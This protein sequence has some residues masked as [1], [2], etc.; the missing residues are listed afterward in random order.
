MKFI[1]VLLIICAA[2][3]INIPLA[4]GFWTTKSIDVGEVGAYDS[5]ALDTAG[6][7]HISYY[8]AGNGDLKYAT[9]A[10][11]KWVKVTVDD[12]GLTSAGYY[13]SIVIDGSGQSHISYINYSNSESS[14]LKY[15]TNSSGK[16]V[17][18]TVETVANTLLTDTSIAIDSKGRAHVSYDDYTNQK[19]KYATNAS[20]QWAVSSPVPD[21]E[22]YSNGIV[23]SISVDSLDNIHIA[24]I[25]PDN[26]GT[27]KLRYMTNA[28]GEWELSDILAD[29]TDLYLSMAIDQSGKPHIIFFDDKSPDMD[30]KY[31]TNASGPWVTETI[32]TCTG[33]AGLSIKTDASNHAHISYVKIAITEDNGTQV[34]NLR[35]LYYGSNSSGSWKIAPVTTKP[36]GTDFS[37]IAIDQAGKTYISFYDSGL[38]YAF[39]ERPG[40]VCT[41]ALST[42][43]KSIVYK[44]GPASVRVIPSEKG[45]AWSATANAG[46]IKIKSGASGSSAKTI[47]VIIS[48]NTKSSQAREGTI[49]VGEQTFKIKQAGGPCTYKLS[50]AGKSVTSDGGQYV[51][52][53]M[54]PDGCQWTAATDSSAF[55]W[56]TIDY[57]TGQ[58][59]GLINY[60]VLENTASSKRN[61]S[62]IVADSTDPSKE[63]FFRIKQSKQ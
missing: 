60:T 56:V 23:P 51:F 7:V 17:N 11:G 42:T 20:G 35:R 8:D 41:Y 47:Q 14:V 18:E 37:S 12:G 31:I 53:V 19:L 38:K 55:S 48:A 9:N 36:G 5:I 32:D 63:K 1:T 58:G 10:S 62:I 57:L 24:Y 52:N 2:F 46:W 26:A 40:Q 39:S 61:G 28:S 43:E 3:F 16:W 30:L 13:T 27:N 25:S 33:G 54:A 4:S 29:G 15:A 21:S 6:K 50:P 45:C 44:G 59:S 22:D 34:S 49:S